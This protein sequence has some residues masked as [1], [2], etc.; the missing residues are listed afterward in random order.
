MPLGAMLDPRMQASFEADPVLRRLIEEQ[1]LRGSLEAERG[2]KDP[3][4]VGSQPPSEDLGFGSLLERLAQ[5]VEA[6]FGSRPG[7]FGGPSE[8]MPT[9]ADGSRGRG[10]ML[11]QREMTAAGSGMEMGGVPPGRGDM[12]NR[13]DGMAGGGMMAMDPR[14]QPGLSSPNMPASMAV[15]AQQ[16]SP[17][18]R[19]IQMGQP[20]RATAPGFGQDL[21]TARGAAE[22]TR[23]AAGGRPSF[24]DSPDLFTYLAG[25][26]RR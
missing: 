20:I 1:E 26:F 3:G 8:P 12:M 11:R 23:Q 5:P 9:Q 2:I 17:A 18:M 22:A 6:G 24:R 13:G 25:L 4:I 15:A 21:G 16:M 10:P 14:Q 7:S 19:G